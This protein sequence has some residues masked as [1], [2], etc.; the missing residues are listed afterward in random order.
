M[1]HRVQIS[2]EDLDVALLQEAAQILQVGGVVAFP[3]ETVYGLGVVAS[4]DAAI[5]RLN[6]LKGRPPDKPYSYHIASVDQVSSI[7]AELPPHA[8]RLSERYWPGPLTLVVPR[9]SEYVGIRV[10]AHSVAN[11]LIERVGEALFVPS[12]NPSG[13]P[14]AT[15]AAEAEAYFGDRVDMILDGGPV[16]IKQSSTVIRTDQDSFHVLR[17]GIITRD[18]VHQLLV[19]RRFLFVCTGNTCRSP[20]A[21]ALFRKHLAAKLG[22]ATEE[23]VEMGYEISSAGVFAGPGS[24]ASEHAQTVIGQRGGNLSYHRSQPVTL[25]LLESVDRVY[26]L[27]ASHLHALQKIDPAHTDRFE[28]LAGHGI[29]DPV[30]GDIA[31]YERCAAE[32]EEAIIERLNQWS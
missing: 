18:N 13:D 9:D 16:Q 19:G 11:R 27:G 7:V 28:L 22:K 14:P 3:T 24:T 10:P 26:A 6:E 2:P 31:T 21:A 23:L 25:E 1:A 29:V 4:S 20:M 15:T 5:R 12:A 17:E 30:G 8:R 32:I